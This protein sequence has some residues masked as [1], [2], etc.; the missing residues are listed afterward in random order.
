[1]IINN[2]LNQLNEKQKD[3]VTSHSGSLLVLAG[4][5][6]GKTKVITCRIANMI[7]NGISPK[8]IVAVSFT[9]KAAK[10]MQERLQMILGEKKSNQVHLST[11]HSFALQLLREFKFEFGFQNSF[12]IASESQSNN[13]LVESLQ[14]CQMDSF[15]K[16]DF[17]KEKISYFKDQ[18]FEEQQFKTLQNILDKNFISKLF[19]TYQ[20]KLKLYNLIDF[21]DIIY[22]TVLGLNKNKSILNELHSRFHYL[23]VDE[24]QDTNHSQFQL[25]QLLGKKSGHVCVVGDDDQS[26]YSWRGAVPT[27]ISDFL[28]QFQNTKIVK[29]EQNYRCSPNILI[30]ANSVIRENTNRQGKELWSQNENSFPIFIRPCENEKDETLY[31]AYEIQR[32]KEQL[33]LN[34]KDFAVLYRSSSQ[35]SIFETT[36]L[37]NKIPFFNFEEFSLYDKKEV[38]DHLQILFFLAN[39]KDYRSLFRLLSIFGCG[40]PID[41]LEK[42]KNEMHEKQEEPLLKI[43]KNHCH[44]SNQ[45]QNFLNHWEKYGSHLVHC[46]T[47]DDFIEKYRNGYEKLGLKKYIQNTSQDM[48]VFQT[49]NQWIE[50]IYD[51]FR[52]LSGDR[53]FEIQKLSEILSQFQ[54]YDP[55][56]TKKNDEVQFLTIHSSKGLEFPVVFLIGAEEGIIPHEKSLGLEKDIEEERRL[57]YVAMT[58]AKIQLKISYCS[59]RNFSRKSVMQEKEPKPSRFLTQIQKKVSVFQEESIESKELRRNRLAKQLFEM[60]HH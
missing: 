2:Y 26:I 29:L 35:I 4:A 6:T 33:S 16:K 18:L 48:K 13:L 46:K 28:D 30:A 10:E 38:Q 42:I 27:I 36:F 23:M 22:R 59:Y 58:R 39:P 52:K 19:V 57:F 44:E 49:K 43:L 40:I 50:K 11:F 3:A 55:K 54:S 32:I 7:E 60:F 1:M 51:N 15:V 21:D 53:R 20:K 9:N 41:F 5:G 8:G 31:V 45:I 37:E 47:V 24:F 17:A 14:E 25:I 34:Y 56:V 12:Q